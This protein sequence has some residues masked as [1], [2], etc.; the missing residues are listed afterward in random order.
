MTTVPCDVR[1]S[2]LGADS[3]SACT[4]DRGVLG[5]GDTRAPE[6]LG[7][8]RAVTVNGMNGFERRGRGSGGWPKSFAFHGGV[9]GPPLD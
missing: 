5:N 3:R 2:T 7:P 1:D 8:V 4:R 6:G 9:L